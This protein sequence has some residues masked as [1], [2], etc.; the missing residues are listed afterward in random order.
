LIT[1]YKHEH[2]STQI[3]DRVDPAWLQPLSG[4]WVWVDLSAPTPDEARTLSDVFHFHELAVEDALA[5]IHHPKV[6]SYGDDL[7]L[8]LHAIDFKAHLSA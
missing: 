6:E 7:Y 2:G 5:E 3:V 4:I 8:I 1:V